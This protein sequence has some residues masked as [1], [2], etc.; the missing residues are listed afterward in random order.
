MKLTISVV[1]LHIDNLL[2][3]QVEEV[4]NENEHA[5]IYHLRGHV[6]FNN[7]PNYISSAAVYVWSY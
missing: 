6:Y 2:R 5:P 1:A 3:E 7:S 4:S